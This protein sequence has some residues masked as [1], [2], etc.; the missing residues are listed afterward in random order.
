MPTRINCHM[1]TANPRATPVIRPQGEKPNIQPTHQPTPPSSRTAAMNSNP[2]PAIRCDWRLTFSSSA[3][4]L[5]RSSMGVDMVGPEEEFVQFVTS[6]LKRVE[7][8]L[9]AP[10]PP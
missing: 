3:A 8:M 5:Y 9:V 6:R 1:P 10:P 7:S 4:F 2:T